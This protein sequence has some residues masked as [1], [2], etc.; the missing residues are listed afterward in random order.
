MK[1]IDQITKK[2]KQSLVDR[3]TFI[4]SIS[5]FMT[6]FFVSGFNI[7]S[8]FAII[9]QYQKDNDIYY[10]TLTN[11]IYENAKQDLKDKKFDN[12]DYITNQLIKNNLVLFVGIIDKKSN[13]Y[14]WASINEIVG[15]PLEINN[16]NMNIVYNKNFRQINPENIKETIKTDGKYII[17]T[18]FYTNNSLSKLIEIILKGNMFLLL[19]F[20]IFGFLLARILARS[21]TKPIKELARGAEE[22]SN[23]NLSFRSNISSY[24]EIGRLASAFNNMAEKLDN[25]YSSLEQQVE[26]RTNELISKNDQLENA[27]GELKEAQ[28]LLVQ[29][30]KM[31]SLGQ[32]TAGLAHEL[33][34]PIN[35][36]YGNL[37]HFKNYSGD[38][39]KIIQ[40]YEEI[41]AALSN[42][43]NEKINQVKEDLEYKFILEDLPALIK[44]CQDGAERCKQIILDLKNFSR[45]D[46]AMI[47]EVDI[48]EGIDSTLN[49]LHHKIK[50]KVVIH[51]E[52]GNI[53]KLS[54]YAGQLNQVFMNILDNAVQA[55]KE[56]GDIYIKTYTENNSV[57][58]IIE[59][60]GSGID[61]DHLSKIFDPFFTTKPVGEGTGLGLSIS[62]KIIKKHNGNIVVESEEGKGTKFILTFPLKWNDKENI[63]QETSNL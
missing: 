37:S 40:G 23:G 29:N 48:H 49:I 61:K 27:Y 24:E 9:S 7:Y 12:I 18:Y 26:E 52:Y 47:K 5:I 32:L 63:I 50:N 59:D 43:D 44:S 28:S 60:N 16:P 34:N 1:L 57:A 53:P 45:L 31:S 4:I 8:S 30:E 35:F 20:I 6:S 14:I 13:K 22:F 21:L 19:N 33:N 55:V 36:I 54:C 42:E 25:L 11:S 2:R 41:S 17:K 62:Y 56:N 10:N 58:I 46:E 3:F 38:L 51:K 15:T 39:I